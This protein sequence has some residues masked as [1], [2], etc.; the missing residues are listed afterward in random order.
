MTLITVVSLRGAPG[1]TTVSLEL[2][3]RWP[4]ESPILIEA[5]PDGGCLAAREGLPASPGLAELAAA[6]RSG[7]S[8]AA[9]DEFTQSLA[10]RGAVVVAPSAPDHVQLSLRTSAA[11]IAAAVAPDPLRTAI[12]DAGRLRKA[13]DAFAFVDAASI[14]LV[15]V[16]P[17]LDA[18]QSLRHHAALLEPLQVRVALSRTSPYEPAEITRQTGFDVIATLPRA[19]DRRSRRQLG[20][21]FDGLARD[22]SDELDRVLVAP[23]EVR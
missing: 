19:H 13:S 15:L 10:P 14:V 5:D 21:A 8:R 12:V 1:V 9:L 6:A 23:E 3:R 7:L 17:A 11:A 18:L 20:L 2:T 16:S 22:L 4:G